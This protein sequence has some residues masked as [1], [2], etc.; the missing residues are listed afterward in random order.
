MRGDIRHDV[1]SPN[2]M[3]GKDPM[4][5]PVADTCCLFLIAYFPDGFPDCCA[6]SPAT[7]PLVFAPLWQRGLARSPLAE[8]FCFIPGVGQR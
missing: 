1:Y 4:A 6:T 3:L 5:W 7:A 8:L 2:G